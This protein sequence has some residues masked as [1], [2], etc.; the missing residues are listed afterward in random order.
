[1]RGRREG[2]QPLPAK[3]RRF[4]AVQMHAWCNSRGLSLK[5]A[6]LLSV[7][8]DRL[9]CFQTGQGPHTRWGTF[10]RATHVRPHARAHA[11][12]DSTDMPRRGQL[13]PAAQAALELLRNPAGRGFQTLRR[14]QFPFRHSAETPQ[15]QI[16]PGPI[17]PEGTLLDVAAPPPLRP[18]K[19]NKRA[20]FWRSG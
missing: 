4:S 8:E 18:K 9:F 10:S 3:R 5:Q 12:N 1:M 17:G 7:S 20:F 19:I 13:V 16:F 6:L 2:R 15:G 11:V 14:L